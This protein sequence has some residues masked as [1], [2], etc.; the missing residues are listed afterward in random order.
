MLINENNNLTLTN[1]RDNIIN[2]DN[3]INGKFWITLSD[4][5]KAQKILGGSLI[6]KTLNLSYKNQSKLHREISGK[7]KIQLKNCQT[8]KFSKILLILIINPQTT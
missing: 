8:K 4:T 5:E 7:I 1:G 6:K 3:F 2:L